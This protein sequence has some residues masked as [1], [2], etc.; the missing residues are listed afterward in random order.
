MIIIIYSFVSQSLRIQAPKIDT[1]V[2]RSSLDEAPSV[3]LSPIS[4][5]ALQGAPLIATVVIVK[6]SNQLVL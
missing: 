2:L 5:A 4:D 6:T 1:S 3:L